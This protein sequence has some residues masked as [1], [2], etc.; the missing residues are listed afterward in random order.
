M[1]SYDRRTAGDFDNNGPDEQPDDY[2][3]ATAVL[4]RDLEALPKHGWWSPPNNYVVNGALM[5]LNGWIFTILPFHAGKT[6]YRPA[7]GRFPEGIVIDPNW[8]PDGKDGPWS[9]KMAEAFAK[10]AKA[11]PN[12][13]ETV[14][15]ELADIERHFKVQIPDNVKAKL[16]GE[17]LKVAKRRW[18]VDRLRRRK[19]LVPFDGSKPVE[20]GS[21]D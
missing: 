4:N 6:A 16:V 18:G 1:Y 14:R 11:Q 12:V 21:W 8:A 20:L 7:S 10:Y 15:R 2:A 19:I 13:Q 17:S 9:G 5:N 3:Q